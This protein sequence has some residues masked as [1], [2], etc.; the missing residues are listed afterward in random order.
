MTLESIT[1][2][3]GLLRQHP[4]LWL[5][6]GVMGV[7]AVLN[8]VIPL[9]GGAFYTQPLALLQ[10]LV[11]PFLVGGVYGTIRA[12]NFSVGAFVESGKTYYFRI[13]LPSLVIF[14]AIIL[15]L[16]LLAIPLAFISAGA[17]A[18][19][20]PLLFGVI[21][22]IA[23]FTFFYDAVA[24]FEETGVFESIRRSVEFVMN[25]IGSVLVFYL[26]NIVA[27]A[28]LGFFG[29]FAWTALLV[30][31]LEPLTTMSPEE[32]QAVMPEDLL[33]LIGTEG[34]WITAIVYAVVIVLFS[35]FL[36]AYKAS[37][38]KNHAGAPQVQQGEYDEKGRWY[39]Y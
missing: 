10:V 8:L 5:I 38:F 26:V 37:F 12:E 14:F 39:K 13:L 11:M 16:I 23:F 18:T 32:L 27:F 7:L 2:A 15:T 28:A 20:T 19:V 3:A 31:K 29:L 4:I 17:A 21:L 33:A 1:G 9:Y 22:S 36:Y 30:E 35:V 24:V 6:G 34:I 25:N